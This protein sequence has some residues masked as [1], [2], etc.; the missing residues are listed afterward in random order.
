VAGGLCAGAEEA[1]FLE[2]NEALPFH[3]LSAGGEGDE[4]QTYT[5]GELITYGKCPHLCRLR[6]IWGYEPPSLTC[7]G[8]GRRSTPAWAKRQR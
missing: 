5:A 2:E 4:I 3:P 6:Q 7:S 1:T 8:T